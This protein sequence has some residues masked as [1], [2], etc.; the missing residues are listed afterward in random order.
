MRKILETQKDCGVK[1][2][3]KSESDERILERIMQLQIEGKCDTKE[4]H[5]LTVIRDRSNL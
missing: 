5:F 2:R 3:S 1:R 4:Y